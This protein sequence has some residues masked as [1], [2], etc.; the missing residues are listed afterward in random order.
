MQYRNLWI[1]DIVDKTLRHRL[2]S[3]CRSNIETPDQI[4][5]PCA[6]WHTVATR[7]CT[8]TIKPSVESSSRPPADVPAPPLTT[9]ATR[10]T[11]T[12]RARP[13]GRRRSESRSKVDVCPPTVPVRN[14]NIFRYRTLI[15]V[16]F[17]VYTLPRPCGG[18]W[19]SFVGKVN[20]QYFMHPESISVI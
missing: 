3:C 20:S 18:A 7:Y 2:R 1:R 15:W 12:N 10:M 5:L 11:K 8:K 16:L 9:T 4:M 6:V 14:L 13:T 19:R 17:F